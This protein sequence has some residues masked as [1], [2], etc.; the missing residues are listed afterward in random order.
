VLVAVAEWSFISSDDIHH[1]CCKSCIDLF[2][3][4]KAKYIISFTLVK[5]VYISK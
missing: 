1:A 4:L 5:W 2:S 3:V